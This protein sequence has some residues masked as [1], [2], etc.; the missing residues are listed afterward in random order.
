V[1]LPSGQGRPRPPGGVLRD[2]LKTGA[3]LRFSQYYFFGSAMT[4]G[5][6]GSGNSP[7]SG[8]EILYVFCEAVVKFAASAKF[9]VFSPAVGAASR[10][11]SAARGG[12]QPAYLHRARNRRGSERLSHGKSSRCRFAPLYAFVDAF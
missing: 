7:V 6:S 2:P 3:A 5:V 8:S 4:V 1:G 11:A 10:T 9:L 12:P